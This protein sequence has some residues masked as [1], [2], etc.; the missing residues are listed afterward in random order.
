MDTFDASAIVIP[1]PDTATISRLPNT[2]ATSTTVLFA[3]GASIAG[4]REL[5]ANMVDFRVGPY[6]DF[7][8]SKRIALSLHGGLAVVV[9]SSEFRVNE[10]A[11]IAGRNPILAPGVVARP[12]FQGSSSETAAVVGGYVGLDGQVKLS[13]HW[14][15]VAGVQ[16][17]YLQ[18]FKQSLGGRQATLRLDQALFANLGLNYSF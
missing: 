9:I 12:N 1:T 10:T 15:A 18:D 16:F 17:Q 3:G 11:T 7:E 4:T 6:V 8:L 5:S 2:P 14:S 13:E